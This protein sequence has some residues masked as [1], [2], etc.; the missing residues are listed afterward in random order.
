MEETRK[1][2]II[3][4]LEKKIKAY[5]EGPEF[6]NRDNIVANL[7]AVNEAV[8]S[9]KG[10]FEYV[11]MPGMTGFLHKKFFDALAEIGLDIDECGYGECSIIDS[12]SIEA[13]IDSFLNA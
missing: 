5:M 4:Y 7:T 8:K 6:P 3:T 10:T 13:D 12:L 9:G 1:N 11:S 2:E